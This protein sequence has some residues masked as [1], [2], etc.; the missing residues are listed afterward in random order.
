MNTGQPYNITVGSDL[1]NDAD[2]GTDRPTINGEHFQRN[3]G[4]QSNAYRV[5]LRL[6]KNFKI[7]SGK[8]GI[9]AEC[10]NV[11]NHYLY[12]VSN[13]T[14]GANQAPLAT[15]GTKSLV[16]GFAPR[17]FQFALRYDF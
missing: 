10:F 5:D 6:A 13:T 12:T 15:F 4:R 8:L 14:W 9:I 16:A 17:T 2:S 1:N 11:N 3:S 7:G